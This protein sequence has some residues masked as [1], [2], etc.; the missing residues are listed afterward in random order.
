MAEPEVFIELQT[1]VGAIGVEVVERSLGA[2]KW[3]YLHASRW[4][5]SG[6]QEAK[7][8]GKGTVVRFCGTCSHLRNSG[9]VQPA[10]NLVHVGQEG[11]P[12]AWWS[13]CAPAVQ[14][15]H[16]MCQRAQLVSLGPASHQA[17]LSLGSGAHKEAHLRALQQQAVHESSLR[18]T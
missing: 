14:A 9:A 16:C 6:N 17:P 13:C 3:W 7:A 1:R 15:L 8:E 12:C 11:V 5:I 4:C 18:M 10:Q 2:A